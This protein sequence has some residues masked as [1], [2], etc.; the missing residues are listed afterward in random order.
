MQKITVYLQ[1]DCHEKHQPNFELGFAQEKSFADLE[2]T[3]VVESQLFPRQNLPGESEILSLL[4]IITVVIVIIAVVIAIIVIVVIV[5][6]HHK[7]KPLSL[8]VLQ[9]NRPLF[10]P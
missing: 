4:G 2:S 1:Q 3:L 6:L 8:H 5:V 10:C 7:H 9:P